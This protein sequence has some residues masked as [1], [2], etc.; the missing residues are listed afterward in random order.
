MVLYLY[1]CDSCATAKSER[2]NVEDRDR[3]I[4][5]E[6]GGVM[7]KRLTPAAVIIH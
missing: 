1:V 3:S 2:R 6:C 4:P 5:C 7:K